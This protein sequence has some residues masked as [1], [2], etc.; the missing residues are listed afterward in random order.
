[1]PR[2]IISSQTNVTP[3]IGV[4]FFAEHKAQF[5]FRERHITIYKDSEAKAT[6]IPFWCNRDDPG[7]AAA[8][9]TCQSQ[10]QTIRQKKRD[11]GL[12][13]AQFAAGD[14]WV[15]DVVHHVGDVYI[16]TMI[17]VCSRWAIAT[18]LPELNAITVARAVQAEWGKA[19][20]HFRPRIVSHDGGPEFKKEVEDTMALLVEHRH[21]ST[22]NRPEGHGLIERLNRDL[23]QLMAK[24]CPKD[25][26]EEHLPEVI[27]VAVDA[28][29]ASVHAVSTEGST[30]VTP[31]ELF[32]GMP[33]ALWCDTPAHCAKVLDST[34]L[35][36]RAR[37]SAIIEAR[38]MAL[39]HV[40]ESRKAY[41]ARLEQDLRAY[42]RLERV[43]Q[44][45]DIVRHAIHYDSKKQKKAFPS[46]SERMVVVDKE[47]FG[48]R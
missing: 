17:D 26:I 29:N 30:G 41:E 14:W 42:A 33:P 25:V 43:F 38:R 22:R 35:P 18:I 23:C 34:L 15:M 8:V 40:K 39:E 5:D 10:L 36:Q 46:Y 21:I 19:G 31:S 1:M 13:L 28:H 4:H 16:L 2:T 45:G 48:T 12:S 20:V 24:M 37:M 9:Q 27:Q 32:H 47:Y 11:P 44:R 7:T 3:I 6:V